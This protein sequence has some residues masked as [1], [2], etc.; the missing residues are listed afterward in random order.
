M[1][2]KIQQV[3]SRKRRYN[4]DKFEDIRDSPQPNLVHL[5]H[6][7]SQLM[8][9]NPPGYSPPSND[10]G[11]IFGYN[12]NLP[13]NTPV[14]QSNQA[15]TRRQPNNQMTTAAYHS[16]NDIDYPPMPMDYDTTPVPPGDRWQ[17][18]SDDLEQRALVA[19]RDAVSKRKQIP[20]FVQKL[21]RWVVFIFP[22]NK[23]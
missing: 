14:P 16:N 2:A 17:A 4:E 15:L 7:Q 23:S 5:P 20:P 8:S 13:T 12:G 22:R 18:P 9:N 21:S 6:Q 1:T 3:G 19:Q 11:D 10:G